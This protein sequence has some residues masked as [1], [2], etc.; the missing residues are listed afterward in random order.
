MGDHLLNGLKSLPKE[1][2]N[3]ARGKGLFCAITI[4]PSEEDINTIFEIKDEFIEFDAWKICLKMKENG[5]LS[6]NTHGDIIRFA[7]PLVIN[8]QQIE[9]AVDIITDSV[10]SFL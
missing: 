9:Q 5:L 1:I 7:P 10:K 2:V 4:N 6:K 3:S 8:K